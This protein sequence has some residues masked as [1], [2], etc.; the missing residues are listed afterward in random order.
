MEL[1]AQAIV[2]QIISIHLEDLDLPYNE[3]AKRARKIAEKL[4]Y[5][6]INDLS[7]YVSKNDWRKQ[8]W[9]EATILWLEKKGY[10][11]F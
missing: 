3:A 2:E 6:E 10:K 7:K 4:S 11:I 5:D 9:K 8:M 1:A